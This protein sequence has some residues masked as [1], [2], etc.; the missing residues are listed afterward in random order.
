M[1]GDLAVEFAR[2]MDSVYGKTWRNDNT[3]FPPEFVLL[4]KNAFFAGVGSTMTKVT[5][6]QGRGH[7]TRVM[8]EIA[9]EV[10]A[11]GKFWMQVAE[12]QKGGV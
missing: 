7:F 8:N 10:E 2:F 5:A 9:D 6:A 12:Q 11:Y 4:M 3:Q 1:T